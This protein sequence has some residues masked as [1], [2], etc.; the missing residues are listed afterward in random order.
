MYIPRNKAQYLHN[1][2]H[3]TCTSEYKQLLLLHTLSSN[4]VVTN[5]P[6]IHALLNKLQQHS[7]NIDTN[8]ISPSVYKLITEN[9]YALLCNNLMLPT[10][11]FIKGVAFGYSKD[12]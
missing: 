2:M 10:D 5:N 12:T 6:E 9:K 8:Y 1:Y 11:E 4:Q 3:L 7:V